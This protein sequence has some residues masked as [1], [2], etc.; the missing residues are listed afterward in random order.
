MSIEAS[1][2][3]IINER[4]EIIGHLAI[5]SDITERKRAEQV[6][7]ES[8]D[9]FR[10][11]YENSTIGIYRT[12]PDGQIKLANP[13]LVRM[14]GYSSFEDLASRNLEKDGFEPTYERKQFLELMEKQGEVKGLESAWTC[15]NGSV[16]FI[17]E[18]V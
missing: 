7:S 3:P 15:K 18:S 13:T 12:T 10:S 1:V 16:I 9:R 6:L 14:L 11:L 8:E 5:E 17:R 4:G 2:N